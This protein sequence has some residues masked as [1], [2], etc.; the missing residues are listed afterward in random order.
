MKQN[1]RFIIL[2]FSLLLCFIFLNCGNMFAEDNKLMYLKNNFNNLYQNNYKQF[3]QIL[4]EVEKNAV[5]CESTDDTVAFLKLIE[6]DSTGAE[7]NEYFS[8]VIE[9]LC[10][11][12]PKCFLD[13]LSSLDTRA[14]TRIVKR[15]KAPLFVDSKDIDAVFNKNKRVIKYDEIMKEYFRK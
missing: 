9:K 13:S 2:I 12:K 1:K 5:N 11:E 10:I 7:F 15:L 6:I 8:E 14:I 3:W 4:A